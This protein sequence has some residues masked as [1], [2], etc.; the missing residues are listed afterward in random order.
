MNPIKQLQDM[1]RHS[2][3]RKA[4]EHGDLET[5][6]TM[7]AQN[8]D[9]IL[10]AIT[11]CREAYSH[12]RLDECLT[13]VLAFIRHDIRDIREVL[14]GLLTQRKPHLWRR[15]SATDAQR[16]VKYAHIAGG[17]TLYGQVLY[18]LGDDLFEQVCPERRNDLYVTWI[19]QA[20]QRDNFQ[21]E[22]IDRLAYDRFFE[23]D[24]NEQ[25]K[26][27]ELLDDCFEQTQNQVIESWSRRSNQEA[28]NLVRQLALLALACKKSP[29]HQVLDSIAQTLDHLPFYAVTSAAELITRTPDPL[30]I[31]KLKDVWLERLEPL[32]RMDD[33]D[34]DYLSR[35]LPPQTELAAFAI[36]V[37]F[38][39]CG[40]TD[41]TYH[42]LDA[43]RSRS[44]EYEHMTKTY[45]QLVE[46]YN[47]LLTELKSV[48]PQV[49]SETSS[50]WLSREQDIESL[51]ATN[52][53]FRAGHDRLRTLSGQISETKSKIKARRD[54][55]N[56]LW[57][58]GY[59]LRDILNGDQRYSVGIR[60]GAALGLHLLVQNSNLDGHTK[61]MLQENLTASMHHE[62]ANRDFRERRVL[63]LPQACRVEICHAL[64]SGIEWM[65]N[66]ANTPK[67]A[68]T[69]T[70]TER[71]V[72]P[73]E[74][75]VDETDVS[76]AA[77]AEADS[78]LSLSGESTHVHETI[79]DYEGLYHSVQLLCAKLPHAVQFLGEYPLRLMRSDDHQRI[80]GQ[81]RQNGCALEFWTR[82]TPPKRVGKVQSR[83]LRLDD[84]TA[85]NSMGLDY[86]LF[87][88]PLI[89]APVIYHEYLHYA[90]VNNRP[91]HGIANEAEVWLREIVFMKN[92]FVQCAP[93]NS[94]MLKQYIGSYLKA[95][96]DI[97]AT[98]LLRRLFEDPR[99]NSGLQSMNET[100]TAL[101]GRQLDETE[102]SVE[103]HQEIGRQ[104]MGIVLNNMVQTWDPEIAYP[105][106]ST[107]ETTQLTETYQTL[108]IQSRTRRNTL[109][110]SEWNSILSEEEC[111][112]ALAVWD[113]WAR[114]HVVMMRPS[115]N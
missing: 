94:E 28:E 69:I 70:T 81:Y 29:R 68:T 87:R 56:W 76:I 65:L 107:P 99:G 22:A 91:N 63:L 7:L 59:L 9:L 44:T 50:N 17:T 101:Y 74:T 25:A 30:W 36:L 8:P 33:G 37:A 15:L 97:N 31:P 79:E 66:I 109:S 93:D 34:R 80:L 108:L 11:D 82:Y 51:K 43:D 4:A 54:Q 75:V 45:S 67:P 5:L 95:L 49:F 60:Q 88:H 86:R 12:G 73:S 47:K 98:S 18:V 3:V 32:V 78:S 2:S 112:Q 42:N 35:Q 96:Y 111:K 103:T 40:A 27:D 46:S 110:I 115:D 52:P 14:E 77:H 16:L 21:R 26:I 89:V 20:I 1:L 62:D 41:K 71:S 100:I 13:Y 105:L 92:I 6:I 64:Q 10:S 106:L 84:R 90:G 23:S 114:E 19:R 57:S 58:P 48:F 61:S 83:Y 53:K 72:S 85:P 24:A 104:N 102:A 55:L 38:G 113:A 39:A